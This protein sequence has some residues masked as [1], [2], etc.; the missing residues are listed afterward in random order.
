MDDVRRRVSRT[1]GNRRYRENVENSVD[2]NW[3]IWMWG[4]RFVRFRIF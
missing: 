3:L 2:R 4:K 1:F